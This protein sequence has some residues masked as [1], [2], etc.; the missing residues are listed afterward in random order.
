MGRGRGIRGRWGTGGE[1]FGVSGGVG[2]RGKCLCAF[3]VGWGEGGGFYGVYVLRL[4]E[5]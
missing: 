3:G 1:R 5:I 2:L 4:K